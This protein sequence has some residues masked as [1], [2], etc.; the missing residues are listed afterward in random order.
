MTNSIDIPLGV[1]VIVIKDGKI[2]I[3]TRTDNGL[4]CGPG[5]HIH[6]GE[7]AED[8]AIRETEEEFGIKV[9]KLYQLGA[10]CDSED[11]WKPS[12]V[13][14]C[15]DYEGEP[16]ND[17]GEMKDARF[18]GMDE[19]SQM[20]NLFPCFAASLVLLMDKLGMHVDGGPGS[21]RYPKGSGK[22]NGAPVD[23][24]G[25]PY[26]FKTVRLP[27]GE[28]GKI[29]SEVGSHYDRYEGKD[30]CI[31]YSYDLKGRSKAYYFE[32][33]GYNE[34]NFYKVQKNKG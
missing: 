28:Y 15:K 13:F 34:Y 33:H 25:N 19:L 29:M 6:A 7:K 8:A 2:L 4:I 23:S 17:D 16:K 18:I 9:N 10:I 22:A 1:G 20:C 5:G 21:G 31:H 3:G 12:M 14:L 11:K 32:N 30:L 24:N 27:V 26:E